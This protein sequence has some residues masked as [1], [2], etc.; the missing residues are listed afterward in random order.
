MS[1]RPLPR[2]VSTTDIYLKAVLDELKG[3]RSDL[4]AKPETAPAG[5][6]ELR[7]TLVIEAPPP[8]EPEATPLPDDFPGKAALEAAGIVTL[9]DVPRS[10]KALTAVS[11]IGSVTANQ[12]LSWFKVNS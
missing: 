6:I 7:E 2:P 11:G 10:G 8:A 9:E 3:L 12:I 4:T 1:D 5:T